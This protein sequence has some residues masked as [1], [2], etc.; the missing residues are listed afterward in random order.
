MAAGMNDYLAKPIDPKKL[1]ETL[2]KWGRGERWQK[3]V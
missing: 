1:K 3:P 2:L